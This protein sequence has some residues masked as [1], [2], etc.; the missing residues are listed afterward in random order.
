MSILEKAAYFKGLAE[1]MSYGDDSKES[2]LLKI[3]CDLVSDMAQEID[4]LRE[5]LDEA[6]DAYEELVDQVDF[7]EQMLYEMDIPVPSWDDDYDDYDEEEDE[8]L[9][10]DGVLYDVT[11]PACGEEITFDEDTLEE[12]GIKCPACGETLEFDL[13]AED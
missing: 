3:L 11:C 5:E 10:Y 12:G 2:K 9:E 7:M 4:E 6:A 1:G 8:E 13:D